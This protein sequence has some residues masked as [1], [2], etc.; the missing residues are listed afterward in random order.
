MSGQLKRERGREIKELEIMTLN[1][2]NIEHVSKDIEVMF[3]GEL[4]CLQECFRKHAG[5]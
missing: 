1:H 5:R 4:H 2:E 3:K